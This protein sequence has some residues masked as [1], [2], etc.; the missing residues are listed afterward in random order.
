M[1]FPFKK[2]LKSFISMNVFILLFQEF[3]NTS[4]I[5]LNILHIIIFILVDQ[6]H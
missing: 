1:L 2:L 3:V 5:Y 4:F 6:F